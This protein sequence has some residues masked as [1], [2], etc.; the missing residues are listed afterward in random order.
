[1]LILSEYW[2]LKTVVNNPS[3]FNIHRKVESKPKAIN[4]PCLKK[5]IAGAGSLDIQTCK[6]YWEL[7]TSNFELKSL[8]N[9]LDIWKK[10]IKNE[11]SDLDKRKKYEK[12]HKLARKSVSRKKKG[13]R[14]VCLLFWLKIY[15]IIGNFNSK[16]VWRQVP[17][18]EFCWVFFSVFLLYSRA[19]LSFSLSPSL[20]LCP[21]HCFNCWII[22]EKLSC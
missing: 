7:V 15:S 11:T 22:L 14:E 10:V 4:I 18:L 1:M 21:F 19:I 6:N 9:F 2:T 8:L 13:E 12:S 3:E 16:L 20:L 5:Q 17:K